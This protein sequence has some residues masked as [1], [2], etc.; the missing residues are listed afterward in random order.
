[1]LFFRININ[2]SGSSYSKVNDAIEKLNFLP[3]EFFYCK[4]YDSQIILHT[5]LKKIAKLKKE[6]DKIEDLSYIVSRFLVLYK[7]K[8]LE[9]TDLEKKNG[10]CGFSIEPNENKKEWFSYK[11]IY[12]DRCSDVYLMNKTKNKIKK[13]RNKSVETLS[14]WDFLS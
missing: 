9:V 10:I 12:Y 6:I 3:E 2:I 14:R 7:G 13:F 8:I 4:N 5:K 1:M 11:D